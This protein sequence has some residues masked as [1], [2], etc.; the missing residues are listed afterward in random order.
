MTIYS[1]VI[2]GG[3]AGHKSSDHNHTQI[4]ES[5]A[6]HNHDH[7]HDHNHDHNHD[8]DH[9]HDAGSADEIEF[10]REQ[11][12]RSGVKTSEVQRGKFRDAIKCS[13]TISVAPSGVAILSAPVEGIVKY[14]DASVSADVDVRKGQLLF[15]ISS[16]QLA[17]GDAVERSRIE[18]QLAQE[19]FQRI[20]N[21]YQDKLVTREAYLSAEAEYLKAKNQYEP[22]RNSGSNGVGVRS[23]ANGYLSQVY[24]QPGDYVEVGQ[25]LAA[26]ATSNRM[27]LRAMV[28]QRYLDRLADISDASLRPSG[29]LRYTTLSA[30]N[31]KLISVGRRVEQG[32]LMLPVV[33]EFDG[34]GRFPDGM[35]ADVVLIGAERDDVVTV[36]L[37]ALT[38]Q[39]GIFY[40]YQQ[41]DDDCYRR[42]QVWTGADDGNNI[43]ILKGLEGGETIVVEGAVNVKM[44]SASGAIPHGHNH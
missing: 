6:D 2:V 26:V 38:E 11:A 12:V 28:S 39:Q 37:S 21:L 25:Q 42:V 31:G 7:D 24:V 44:A 3:C 16:A 20:E 40:V 9:D 13:G 33:F 41:I 36:P 4:S 30:L 22:L 14:A 23:T 29:A 18:F 34:D 15:N 8:H 5:H 35:Y 19:N 27:Q 1:I 32:S 43:E 17:S 10:S